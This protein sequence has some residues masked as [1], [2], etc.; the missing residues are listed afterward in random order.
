LFVIV[1]G[2]PHLGDHALLRGASVS[3]VV[4]GAALV[5]FAFIGFDEVI[6]L[7]E[8][9]RDPVRTVPRGLL[10]ALAISTIL[11]MA[12]SVASVSVL[13]AGR[14]GAAEQPLAAVMATVIGS[15]GADLVAG[16]ALIA[17]TN[18]VLLCL[19][20][21]SR[22]QYG[23]SRRGALPPLVARISGRGAPW[24]AI[25]IAVAG[26]AFSVVVGDLAL[27]A[28]VTDFAVYLV[29]V[30]VNLTVIVLRYR[31]PRRARPFR[32]PFSAGRL[33]LPTVAALLMVLILIPSL[34]LTALALGAALVLVGIGVYL[35]LARST[36]KW[37]A[38]PVF[39][40]EEDGGVRRRHVTTEEAAAVM[41]A[42]NIDSAAV[43]WD[44]E[45]FRMGLQSELAHGRADPDTNVTDDDLV[46]TGK[47]ALAHLVE[48]PDYYTRLA[49]MEDTA[50][51]EQSR[52]Q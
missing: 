50:F 4:G 51:E 28:S 40:V 30:A 11:Y 29:F 52:Q 18:T 46:T 25:A 48:I 5:F 27:V 15:A 45:Q 23:M 43:A 20:A 32:V 13:G 36:S 41:A 21:S 31:Q 26:A 16:I 24:M 49:A 2:A 1:I 7:S 44:V 3:G 19:T 35:S 9:T 14:L 6:T 12:V 47:I 38:A 10:L 22:L 39:R 42:L 37:T 17:T 8:E 33:P 34:D